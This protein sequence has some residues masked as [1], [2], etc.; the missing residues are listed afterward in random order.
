MFIARWAS[1]AANSIAH[2]ANSLLFNLKIDKIDH[3]SFPSLVWNYALDF[4]PF[5]PPLTPF[6]LNASFTWPRSSFR[7]SPLILTFF[8]VPLHFSIS[9]FALTFEP[10]FTFLSSAALLQNS[11]CFSSQ[12]LSWQSRLHQC[13]VRHLPHLIWNKFPK[14]LGHRTPVL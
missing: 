6:F 12:S 13:L 8:K 4:S 3:Y 2:W 1:N 7:N 10:P 11:R 5:F 9:D 14:N